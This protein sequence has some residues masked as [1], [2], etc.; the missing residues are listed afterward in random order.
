M[1]L[2]IDKTE[3]EYANLQKSLDTV[4]NIFEGP[5]KQKVEKEIKAMENSFEKN[6]STSPLFS[7]D[8]GKEFEVFKH[9]R[10]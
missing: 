10:R 8:A 9:L 5:F 1:N 3:K 2:N 6:A 4:S 7:G